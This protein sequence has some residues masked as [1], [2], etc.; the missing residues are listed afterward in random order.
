MSTRRAVSMLGVLAVLVG[1][2]GGPGLAQDAPTRPEYR[3]GIE[4]VLDVN[5]WK[6]PEVSRQVWVRPDGRITLP[7][8][9]EV[10]VEG[11]TTMAL[12]D[13]LTERLK[14]YYTDP[15]VTV[16]LTEIN[17]FNVYFLG[18]VTTPGVMKLRSP[19]TFLQALAMAGGFQE[20]ADT[21]DVVLVRWEG[22]Q[23]KRIPVDAK[24]L[25]A[26][27]SEQDFLL[28]PGDVVIVP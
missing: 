9:G 6:N 18:R 1:A 14:E 19:K 25:I 24:K 16:S 10:P 3:I 22:G 23:E 26:K 13:L 17:S 4:D 7:M 28:R 5:V 15:L 8:V 20:F 2:A 21:G 11:L 12:V 27:G